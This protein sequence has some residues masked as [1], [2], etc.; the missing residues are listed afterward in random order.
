MAIR[1]ITLYNRPL[2]NFSCST[3]QRFTFVSLCAV[4]T[5][6]QSA[7]TDRGAS[8]VLALTTVLTALATEL[9]ING[10]R[11]KPG[12]SDASSLVSALILTLL[13]PNTTHP[14]CA[15]LAAFFAIAVVKESFGGLGA[16]WLNPALGGWLFIRFAWPEAF[17]LSLEASPLSFVENLIAD[18]PGGAFESNPVALL[19]RNGFGVQNTDALTPLLNQYVFS[20]FNIEMP[21]NYLGFF[22]NPG[23]GIIAD[24]G[25]FGLLFGTALLIST[26]AS[27][28]ALSLVYTGIV[29]FLVRVSGSLPLGGEIGSGDML[30]CLFSGGTLVAAFLLAVEPV[31]S[32][33]SAAGRILLVIFAALLTFCFRYIKA[34]SYGAMLAVACA[35]V[36]TP[37]I[38]MMEESLIYERGTAKS[39]QLPIDDAIGGSPDENTDK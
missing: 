13:L 37:L 15:A 7:W 25:I 14:L 27:R 18:M 34:E 3:D 16:N 26:S 35:N 6:A 8:L 1:D 10:L 22:V 23:T 17:N 21:A 5:I 28:F 30:F 32:P 2:L 36:L 4:L 31:T 33:K 39:L 19:N 9:I 20:F 11:K 12:L 29:V 24:R 38:R